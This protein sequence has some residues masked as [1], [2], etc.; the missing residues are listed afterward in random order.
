[1]A[2]Q[3]CEYM[4]GNG[5]YTRTEDR[6]MAIGVV[7]LNGALVPGI[8]CLTVRLWGYRLLRYCFLLLLNPRLFIPPSS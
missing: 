7:L 3:I 2:F 1:M 4:L 6:F 8:V 5:S